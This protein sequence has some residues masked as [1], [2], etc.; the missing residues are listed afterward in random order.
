MNSLEDVSDEVKDGDQEVQSQTKYPN[1]KKQKKQKKIEYVQ[2]QLIEIHQEHLAMLE[3]SEKRPQEFME[4]MIQEQ[5]EQG[6][7]ERERDRTFFLKLGKL[8][9]NQN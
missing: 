4:R 3:R 1:R 6:E 7:R 2:D 9:T 5:K 8:F